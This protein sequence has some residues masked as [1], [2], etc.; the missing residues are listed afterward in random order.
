[1]I[2]PIP[3]PPTP[4]RMS[5]IFSQISSDTT[6]LMDYDRFAEYL[7]QVLQLPHAVFE[8]PTFFYSPEALQQC[9]GRD[10]QVNVNQFLDTLM[11][12]ACPP[13]LMWLPLLHRMASVE[14][15]YHPV[16]CDACQVGWAKEG[17][18]GGVG[19]GG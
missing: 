15:V 8:S 2:P 14:R 6:G 3:P 19:E 10:Q 12:D 1:M 4:S 17:L 11:G 7:Q 16:M 18:K 13:C 5:D 9:F